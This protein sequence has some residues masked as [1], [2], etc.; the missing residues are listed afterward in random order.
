MRKLFYIVK[1]GIICLQKYE[2]F[3]KILNWDKFLAK[4]VR[5]AKAKL[6]IYE[7]ISSSVVGLR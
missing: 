1:I 4:I 5:V 7:H 3:K 6:E 2:H